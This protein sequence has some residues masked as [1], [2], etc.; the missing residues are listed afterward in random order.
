MCMCM[1]CEMKFKFQTPFLHDDNLVDVLLDEFFFFFAFL[2]KND[3]NFSAFLLCVSFI[4]IFI[5]SQQYFVY[6]LFV[7]FFDF[8]KL[9]FVLEWFIFS[10]IQR[11]KKKEKQKKNNKR[12]Y[13]YLSIYQRAVCNRTRLSLCH[14][15]FVVV[16]IIV[17]TFC[18]QLFLTREKKKA[19]T[20]RKYKLYDDMSI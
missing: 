10:F 15:T 3:D 5:H 16:D 8:I 9:Y 1:E 20:K 14:C 11:K 19:T 4:I 18:I 2:I 7:A 12:M 6:H 13:V 17:T